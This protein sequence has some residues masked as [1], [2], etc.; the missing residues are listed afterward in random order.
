MTFQDFFNKYNGKYVDW[1]GYYGAQC[2]D[3]A[4]YYAK[5]VVGANPFTGNAK[6][7]PYTYNPKYYDWIVNSI[8]AVP[9][10]GDIIIWGAKVGGGY[11]HIAIC[12][13]A[14][15]LSFTSMDQ[16]WPLNTPAHLQTHSDLYYGVLGWLR[17]KQPVQVITD[18]QA[19]IQIKD[20]NIND[21]RLNQVLAQVGL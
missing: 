5:E 8:T 11:G 20:L 7:I 18:R 19:L 3:L 15:I 21:S 9:Q 12:N 1:D 4:Q 16:N 2:V 10:K 6:D 17:P 14:N 13:T